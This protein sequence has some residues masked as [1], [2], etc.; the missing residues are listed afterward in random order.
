MTGHILVEILSPLWWKGILITFVL[1]GLVLYLAMKL[2]KQSQRILSVALGVCFLSGAILIHPYLLHLGKWSV[3][4]SMPLHMCTFSAIISGWMMIKPKQWGFE[5]LVYW[6]IPGGIHSII[7]PEFIHGMEGLLI[8]EYYFL[9]GNIV[10]APLY[11]LLINKMQLSKRSWWSYFLY[12]QLCIPFIGSINWLF[13]SNYMYLVEKPMADNPFII[14]DWP[15]YILLL[16]IVIILHFILI[17]IIFR[18]RKQI[19]FPSFQNNNV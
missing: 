17:Y 18:P 10:L 1:I 11:L 3:K 6:G 19:V 5:I 13:N 2:N 15:W 8:P 4:T 16:E 14:G 12:T 7:T 9:H